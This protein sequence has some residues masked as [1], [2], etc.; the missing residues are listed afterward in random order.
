MPVK[1]LRRFSSYDSSSIS[2]FAALRSAVAK[3]SVNRSYTDA[4]SSR[5]SSYRAWSRRSRA[6]LVAQRSSQESAPCLC[7]PVERLPEV[8]LGRN[9]CVRS[10][11]QQQKLAFDTKQFGHVPAPFAALRSCQ[12]LADCHQS[13][14]HL[15]DT[16]QAFRE[17]AEQSC[18]TQ[19]VTGA[20]KLFQSGSKKR[21]S[22]DAFSASDQEHPPQTAGPNLP[23]RERVPFRMLDQHRHEAFGCR[24]IADEERDR[25]SRLR[26]RI[27]H[28]K[29]MITCSR[30]IYTA[31]RGADGLLRKTLK[32][33]GMR[34]NATCRRGLVELEAIQSYAIDR[35]GRAREHAL[36]VMERADL[37]SQIMQR[38]SHHPVAN[39]QI[40]RVGPARS[41]AAKPMGQRQL[42]PMLATYRS[43]KRQPPER[44]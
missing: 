4:K 26:Q 14:T 22:S 6:R 24:Q 30:T 43:I 40:R 19:D 33:Q 32:P 29:R 31:L 28:R 1:S 23:N 18:V 25:A 3:P 39:A 17:H 5:A 9:G 13:F 12:R 42:S 36:D 37:V 15:A 21:Q 16:A 20:A 35:R 7:A 8:I 11:L 41:N 34:K 44:R 10:I 38:G 27:T 2:A